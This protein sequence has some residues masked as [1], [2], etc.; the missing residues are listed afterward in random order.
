MASYARKGAPDPVC[1]EVGSIMSGK[2][3]KIWNEDY[4]AEIAMCSFGER[5]LYYNC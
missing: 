4:K 2:A 5:S 3:S 1:K